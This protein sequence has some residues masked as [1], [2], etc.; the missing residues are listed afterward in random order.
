VDPREVQLEKQGLVS[1]LGARAS[2]RFEV[3]KA[4]VLLYGSA[5]IAASVLDLIWREFDAAHQPIGG[6][7]NLIPGHAVFACLIAVWMII[8]GV[9]VLWYRTARF[10]ALALAVTYFIFGMCCLPFFYAVP[11]RFGVRFAVFLGLLDILFMQLILVAAALIL[12]APFAGPGS[13]WPRK[14]PLVSRWTFGLGSTLFGLGHLINGEVVAPMVPNWMPFGAKYWI[15]TSGIGFVLAGVAILGR[16]LDGLAARL[17]GL[18]LLTFEVA[19]IPLILAHPKVHVVW[20]SNAYNLVAAGAVWIFA[21]SVGRGPE[22]RG[23]EL[24]ANVAQVSSVS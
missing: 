5:T 12:Y 15:V 17:L 1:G 6:F 8:G 22:H 7:G 3:K 13:S 11:Q 9:G 4:G 10:G 23:H 16:V 2:A 14:L 20:G 19:L 21:S 18:M 24:E